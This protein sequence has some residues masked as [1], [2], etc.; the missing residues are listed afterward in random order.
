MRILFVADLHG[1]DLIFKKSLKAAETYEVSAL[2]LAGDL[3]AKDIRPIINRKDNSFL[4]NYRDKSEVVSASELKGIEGVLSDTGHY[5]FYCTETEFENLKRDHD[6]IFKIM[7]EKIIDKLRYWAETIIAQIDL[8][9]KTVFITPG[10]DDILD[11]DELLNQYENKGIHSN[12]SRPYEFPANE[13]ISLDYS[14][15]TPWETPREGTEK[16]LS[17]MIKRKVKQLKNPEKAIFN[18]HCPPVD[19]RIDLAPE[20]DKNLKP[21]IVPGADTR[22]HVGSES[23]RKFIEACQPVLSL[24][25]HVHES[26]GVDRIGKTICL[27]PG[28]EYWNGIL[29]GYIIDIDNEGNVSKYF[30]IEG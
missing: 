16:E 25:G 14:N 17:K 28:S 1:A 26:P 3:T 2:I 15:Q 18:F 22:V 10:N 12:L 13:M 9:K 11:I 21:I 7:D 27:N 24:H 29:H 5:F 30:R 20:L 6:E 23:V 4:V 8:T 19:T